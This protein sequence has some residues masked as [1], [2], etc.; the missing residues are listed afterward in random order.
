MPSVLCVVSFEERRSSAWQSNPSRFSCC[1]VPPRICNRGFLGRGGQD[2]THLRSTD[3]YDDIIQ[4]FVDEGLITEVIRPLKQGKEASVHLCAALPDTGHDLLALKIYHPLNQRD[5]RDES[6]YRDGEFIKE[7]RVRA[8]LEGKTRFGRQVQG[9][10]WVHREWETLKALERSTVPTPIPI[11][12]TEAAILMTY[13]GNRETAA[14]RLHEMRRLGGPELEELWDQIY[15]A[16]EGMLY[17]D[18]VHADL[19]QYNI[20]VWQGR[21]TLIDFPQTVDA[22]K[23]RYA[24]ELVARDVRRVGEWFARQGVEHPWEEMATDLW[25]A[26]NHADLLPD[27][28]R[29]DRW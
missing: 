16:I 3:L 17:R 27:E 13:V 18:L 7:R 29:P 5:F 12:S 4:H 22:R 9:G 26:W 23:N 28:L 21:V 8:A 6:Y 10:L 15:A 25:T 14:P 1:R 24:E 11:A 2:R 19:S 20:L